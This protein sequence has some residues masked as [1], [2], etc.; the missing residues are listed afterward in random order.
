MAGGC[1]SADGPVT[2]F[3][4]STIGPGRTVTPAVGAT[5][6]A[7]VAGPRRAAPRPERRPDARTGRPRR[8]SWPRRR[9]AVYQ[10]TL[11]EEPDKGY[12]VV[13]EFLRPG[14]AAEA[15]AD[16]AALPR[17]RPGQGPDPEQARVHVIRSVG[18]TVIF[19]SWLPQ[20]ADGSGRAGH[21]GRARA[22]SGPVVGYPVDA[23]AASAD[24]QRRRRRRPSAR[25]GSRL[26]LR[27]CVRGKSSSGQSRQPAIRWLGPRVAF[28]AL[29]A[30]S[31]PGPQ[32]RRDPRR[33]PRRARPPRSGPAASRRRPHRAGPRSGARSRC[34]RGTR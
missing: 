14:R 8:R 17:H 25:T 27:V 20:G 33:R 31:M 12:I 11:P 29:T 24:R 9:A 30:A 13:Y 3:P 22:R 16:Q 32:R 26:T 4:A 18:T 19:Y 2:T 10:V 6:A 15:A 23:S 28:A 7:L 34:P 5:R 1:G 21:P